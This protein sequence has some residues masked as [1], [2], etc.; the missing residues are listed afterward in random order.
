MERQVRPLLGI[1]GRAFRRVAVVSVLV[2]VW[3]PLG[4]CD[5][6]AP[7]S[8]EPPAAA[9][10][11]VTP[12]PVRRQPALVDRVVDA[13]TLWVQVVEPGGPLPAFVSHKVRLLEIDAP[14][15]ARA[16]RPASCFGPEATAFAERTLPVGTRVLLEADAQAADVQGRALRYVYLPD[17]RMLNELAVQQGYA[18]ASLHLPNDRYIDRMY[19]AEHEARRDG[20]GLWGA[21]PS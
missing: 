2:A 19:A 4:R 14:E 6:P 16:G 18:K 11:V 13:D 21:C 5:Y 20:R 17:G 10:P 15:T 8:P 9:Q 12:R 3:V 7:E 1:A